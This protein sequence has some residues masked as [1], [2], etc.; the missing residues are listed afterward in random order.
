MMTHLVESSGDEDGSELDQRHSDEEAHALYI[1]LIPARILGDSR[2][3]PKYGSTTL[4]QN[5][6]LR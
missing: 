5:Q 3:T 4:R 1:S 6:E 2:Q